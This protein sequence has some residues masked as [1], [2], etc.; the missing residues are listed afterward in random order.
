MNVLYFCQH[1]STPAGSTGQRAYEMARSLLRRGHEVTLICGSYQGAISGLTIPFLNGMRRGKVDGIDVIEFDLAYSN[2]DGFLKR[3]FTF[4]KFVFLSTRFIFT[5]QYDLVFATSTP[6]TVGI[7]GIFARWFY[8]KP[9]VFEVRDLWPEL[10]KAMGVIKNPVI[11]WCLSVLEGLTYRSAVRMI[12][13]SPGMVNGIGNRGIARDRIA[14]IPNGCDLDLFQNIQSIARP[15]GVHQDDLLVIYT[16][17]HGVANGL[18]AI[19]DAAGV[20]KRRGRTDIKLIL[21]GQG[22]LKASLQE[23]AKQEGLDCVIFLDPMSKAALASLM[24]TADLGMQLLIN[25]PAFYEG[26][27]PNKFFDYLAAGLPIL[28]NYP[29]WLAEKIIQHEC[30]F[31]VPPNDPSAFADALEKAALNQEHLK[32]MGK[33]AKQLALDE[34]DRTSLAHQWVDVLEQAL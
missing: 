11:L 33:N 13:L 30:G 27:S 5:L 7:P 25:V 18:D 19:L 31:V 9:F 29:G 15:E 32:V 20:L 26:T 24:G 23:R 16:G 21:V 4:L 3:S 6:L 1:F 10:P 2:Q 12:G 8:R 28:N 34:F 17:T 14:M 22:K